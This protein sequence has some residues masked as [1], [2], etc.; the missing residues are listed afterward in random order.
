M[1]KVMTKEV[2]AQGSAERFLSVVLPVF[3][4]SLW[5]WVFHR[6]HMGYSQKADATYRVAWSWRLKLP[7]DSNGISW[8]WKWIPI[9]TLFRF[10]CSLRFSI[11]STKPRRCSRRSFTHLDLCPRLGEISRSILRV[12]G[13]ISLKQCSFYYSRFWSGDWYRTKLWIR[14]CH[15]LTPSSLEALEIQPDNWSDHALMTRETSTCDPASTCCARQAIRHSL[16]RRG[17]ERPLSILHTAW[18]CIAWQQTSIVATWSTRAWLTKSIP[19]WFSSARRLILHIISS[20]FWKIIR[21]MKMYLSIR[22]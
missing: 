22:T 18:H 8:E 21:S 6:F 1:H 15:R 12:Q 16:L 17:S 10:K 4:I 5:K 9:F 11:R 13:L 7:A 20:R 14:V 19:A 3:A 2:Y